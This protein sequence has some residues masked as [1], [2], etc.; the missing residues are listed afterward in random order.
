LGKFLKSLEVWLG[1]G[2]AGASR[3]KVFRTLLII[4]LAG[5]ALMILNS[6]LSAPGSGGGDRASPASGSGPPGETAAIA[7]GTA[8]NG[9][10]FRQYEQTYESQMKAIL[11][12]IVGV[13]DVEVMVTV[14]STEEAVYEK[15]TNDT[16]QTTNEQDQNGSTRHVTDVKRTG[17][18]VMVPGQGSGA[19]APLVRKHMKPKI[20]GV[21]VVARGAENAVVKRLIAEAVERGM[22]VPAHRISVV[23]RKS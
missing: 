21:V 2:A 23:P 19:Q 7:V 8:Q 11:E 4:G 9:D 18:A 5:A 13:S 16:Q 6:Y 20:R 17:D 10:Y 22:D 1:A 12:Q 14:E 15:N 3:V